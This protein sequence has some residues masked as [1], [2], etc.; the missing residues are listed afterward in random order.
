MNITTLSSLNEEV[1]Q[2][3]HF[4]FSFHCKGLFKLFRF[5]AKGHFHFFASLQRAFS[6]STFPGR[7][8]LRYMITL[9]QLLLLQKYTLMICQ[10]SASVFRFSK[11]T[12]SAFHRPGYPLSTRKMCLS[13]YQSHSHIHT[14]SFM[15]NYQNHTCFNINMNKN[16]IFILLFFMKLYQ[17]EKNNRPIVIVH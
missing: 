6:F 7:G 2:G 3:G 13:F 11:L 16:I 5:I 14:N 8:G 10:N 9:L 12:V 15:F 17:I 1:Y 4:H